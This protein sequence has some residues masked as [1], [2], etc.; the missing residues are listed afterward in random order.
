MMINNSIKKY[1][2]FSIMFFVL[3][4]FAFIFLYKKISDN[5]EMSRQKQI[6]WEIEESKKNEINSLGKVIA[7]S[8]EGINFLE[9]HFLKESDIVSFLGYIEESSASV[10]LRTEV[11]S[12]NT[13]VE[14]DSLILEIKSVGPFDSLYRFV[15]LL[16]NSKYEIEITSF[17]LQ[18]EGSG[19]EG[20]VQNWRGSFNIKV[21]TFISNK[22]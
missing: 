10:F 2:L 20:G 8:Q 18:K 19:V 6:Q 13:S 4:C 3:V 9:S 17:D 15:K 1:L 22:K 14:G 12:V 16:E 11:T 21:L 5:E 7:S